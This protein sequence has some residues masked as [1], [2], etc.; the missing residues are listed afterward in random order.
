MAGRPDA[1]YADALLAVIAAPTSQAKAE[2]LAAITP[3][4]DGARFE[5]PAMPRRPGRAAHYREA[6][7]APRR[8]RGLHDRTARLHF[9][10]AIHHIELSAVDLAALLCLRASGAPVALHQEFLAIAQEEAAHAALL[11]QVLVAEGFPP[12]TDPVHHR[13][14]DSAL[15]AGDLG[16][17]LVVVPRFLEARGL[18][19]SAELLPRLAGIDRPSHAA[20]ERIYRDEIR[21]VATG[22]RW[23]QW[24][25]AANQVTTIA[26]FTDTV[27]THFGTQLPSPFALDRA[28]RAAAGFSEAECAVLE[29]PPWRISAMALPA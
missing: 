29:R 5:A 21:H 7:Q 3:P 9:L 20:I 4:G 15:A 6:D 28:G 14:W 24:W 18:D 22:T 27:R 2:R 12:G 8:K 25:C 13:L 1:R 26:H 16:S 11:E 17:Q 10:H 19:V 23:H